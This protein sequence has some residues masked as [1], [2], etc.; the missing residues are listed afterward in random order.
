MDV[1]NKNEAKRYYTIEEYLELEAL[2]EGRSEYHNGLIVAMAGGTKNH[3]LLCNS[4]GTALDIAIDKNGKNCIF[5]SAD[6]KVNI[7]KHNRFLYPDASVIC[8]DEPETILKNPI[9]LIEV[10]SKSSKNYDKGEKFEY[11]RSLPSFKEYM[12][13]YQTMPKVQTWYKEEK[14]LWRI[15]NV[16]GLEAVIALHSIGLEIALKDI[17]KRIKSFPDDVKNPY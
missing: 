6:M 14:D 11:Y 17:Y 4:I 7:E 9:L 12:I 16:E 8:N 13:I 15:V 10:L 3:N 1:E 5:F 2:A